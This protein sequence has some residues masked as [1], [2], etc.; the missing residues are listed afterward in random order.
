[1][2]FVPINLVDGWQNMV[3][4]PFFPKITFGVVPDV[5]KSLLEKNST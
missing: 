4:D 1:M 3:T 2:V 5:I